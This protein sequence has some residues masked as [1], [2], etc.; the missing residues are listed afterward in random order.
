MTAGLYRS[1]ITIGT[2]TSTTTMSGLQGDNGIGIGLLKMIL[3]L[4]IRSQTDEEEQC[5]CDRRLH[6][7]FYKVSP[8]TRAVRRTKEG[9]R[10]DLSQVHKSPFG[11]KN[12]PGIPLPSPVTDPRPNPL[13]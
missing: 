12:E 9:S 5:V 13:I 6:F 11:P 2:E 1:H 7:T 8:V 4:R 10:C 3:L